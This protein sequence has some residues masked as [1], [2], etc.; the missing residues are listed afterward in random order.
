MKKNLA[1]FAAM[2]VLLAGLTGCDSK[3]E[4]LEKKATALFDSVE[5][6]F[7]G[8]E[9][10]LDELDDKLSGTADEEL[11]EPQ[12]EQAPSDAAQPAGDDIRPEIKEAID[13]YEAFFKEYAGF[14]AS[15]D[16]SDMSALTQYMS[17]LEQYTETMQKLDDMENADLTDAEL[18]YYTQVKKRTWREGL[19]SRRVLC[20]TPRYLSRSRLREAARHGILSPW[21]LLREIT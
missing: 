7:D 12:E 20:Y 6:G 19:S 11:Q 16:A 15:Y 17:M 3:G 5:D 18:Q 14:M 9:D 13:S 8:L 2:A 4:E 10:K 1:L 21:T